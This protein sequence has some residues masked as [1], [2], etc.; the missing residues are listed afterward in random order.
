MAELKRYIEG[1]I[2]RAIAEGMDELDACE[3]VVCVASARRNKAKSNRPMKVL[4]R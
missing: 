1:V 4:I 2:D 3:R